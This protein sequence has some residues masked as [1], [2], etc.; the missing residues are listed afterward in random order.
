M[1]ETR[2]DTGIAAVGIAIG[3]AHAQYPVGT[4]LRG[5]KCAANRCHRPDAPKR[6]GLTSCR[7]PGRTGRDAVLAALGYSEQDIAELQRT[8]VI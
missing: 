8:A 1:P 7:L 2:V 6:A 5:A 4:M 3:R